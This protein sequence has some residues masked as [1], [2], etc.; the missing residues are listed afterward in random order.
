VLNSINFEMEV[1]QVL[2]IIGPN[3][4]GK[5]SLA[6]IILGLTQADKG[7]VSFL[8]NTN[9]GYMPQKFTF[10]SSLPLSVDSFFEIYHGKHYKTEFYDVLSTKFNIK[11]LLHKQI[12]SLS[13]GE[14]QR[15]VLANTLLSKPDL[16]ILD[17]PTQAVD[18]IGQ[19]EFY[20][21]IEDIRKELKLTIIII[22][23]DLHLVM[24]STDKVI[25]LNGHI[26]CQGSAEDVSKHKSYRDLFGKDILETMGIYTH[27][28]DH[29]H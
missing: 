9:L 14:L 4:S 8:P 11:K 10:N 21:I 29:K 12:L 5:T 22:S 15:V 2:T 13:G 26:C 18:I 19:V 6:K 28:H 25:C 7:S 23:H 1:G 24:K 20:N 16:L 17:E 3:G 27:H